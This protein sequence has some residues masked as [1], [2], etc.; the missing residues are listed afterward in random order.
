MLKICISKTNSSHEQK[1]LP[2]R[3]N[4]ELW[5]HGELVR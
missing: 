2:L 3:N 5:K 1:Y 4:H